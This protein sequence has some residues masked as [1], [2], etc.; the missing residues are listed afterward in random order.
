MI[1]RA[2]I[3]H[4]ITVA[5]PAYN[6]AATLEDVVSR[7]LKTLES[8]TAGGVE[9]LIVDDG[10][11][12]QTGI[13][14]RELAARD[15]RVRFHSHQRNLGFAA[16]QKSCFRHATMDWIFLIPADGQ[17]DPESLFD[18]LPHT[19]KSDLILGVASGAYETGP[20]A[21]NSRIYHAAARLLL[22][23]PQENFGPCLMIRR[24]LVNGMTLRSGTPVLMT[25][26]AAKAV[27]SGAKISEARVDKK[28]RRHGKARGGR[29]LHLTPQIA[30]ELASLFIELKFIKKKRI[31]LAK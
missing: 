6:E 1:P 20:R 21:L 8:A 13:V 24:S 19:D 2:K 4:G 31:P 9:V 22:D 25:E 5:L 10:S 26:I 23:L 28:P 27:A 3:D 15:P 29:M 14:A 18:F 30:A 12:D 16:A 17:I 11:T 7:S